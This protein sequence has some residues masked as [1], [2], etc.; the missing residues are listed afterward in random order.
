[1]EVSFQGGGDV[2]GVGNK[3]GSL[4]SSRKHHLTFP[5]QGGEGEKK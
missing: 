2:A 5:I 1:M 3:L 4:G